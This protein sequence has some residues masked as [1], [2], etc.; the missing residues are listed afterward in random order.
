MKY[1]IKK[2]PACKDWRGNAYPERY[3]VTK[4]DDRGLRW[5]GGEY[6]TRE[7]AIAAMER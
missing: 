4:I 5:D 2:L 7:A 3:G 1:V 6:P